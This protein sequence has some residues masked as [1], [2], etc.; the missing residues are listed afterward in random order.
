MQ[1]HAFQKKTAVLEVLYVVRRDD[2]AK[3]IFHVDP[4][5]IGRHGFQAPD[6]KPD[7]LFLGS[8]DADHRSCV[9][10]ESGLEAHVLPEI[11]GVVVDGADVQGLLPLDQ[12][13]EPVELVAVTGAAAGLQ[14]ANR[15]VGGSRALAPRPPTSGKRRRRIAQQEGLP[16]RADRSEPVVGDP[17]LRHLACKRSMGIADH[18]QIADIVV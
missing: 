1:T 15:P 8:I 6:S 13:A 2:D 16:G 18:R 4:L 10:R 3:R 11:V 9:L 17:V 14:E 12:A 7:Y 5:D